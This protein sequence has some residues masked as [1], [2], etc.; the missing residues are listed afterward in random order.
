MPSWRR[1]PAHVGGGN[2]NAGAATP[3]PPPA[4]TAAPTTA[5]AGGPATPSLNI[6]PA[7]ARFFFL[8]DGS[9][10]ALWVLRTAALAAVAA[11]LVAA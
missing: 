4:T 9:G 6:S 5:A 1:H 2:P 7:A 8:G 10:A 3:A 11:L